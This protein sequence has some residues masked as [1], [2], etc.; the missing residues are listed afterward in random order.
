MNIDEVEAIVARLQP[1]GL[2]RCEIED[3]DGTAL[4]FQF[5]PAP[6]N[7]MPPNAQGALRSV[8]AA[9]SAP[10]A[11]QP[12]LLRSRGMGHFF[13]RHPLRDMDLPASGDAVTR[14]GTVGYLQAGEVLTEVLAHAD[15][16]L[17]RQLTE[18]G[19]LVGWGTAL[20]EWRDAPEAPG[21]AGL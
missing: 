7:G 16:I 9:E 8:S 17:G 20:Y 18:D 14:G 1:Y 5:L 4:E 15:G 21:T 6:T 11:L 10:Q 12:D 13:S 19:S 3:A 2:E